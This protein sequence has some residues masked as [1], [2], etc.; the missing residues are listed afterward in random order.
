MG[1]W[2][3]ISFFSVHFAFLPLKIDPPN[4]EIFVLCWENSCLINMYK[5][6]IHYTEYFAFSHMHLAQV[7]PLYPS[8]VG[9]I[10]L[11]KQIYYV[12]STNLGFRLEIQSD[13]YLAAYCSVG[14]RLYLAAPLFN[15]RIFFP[16]KIRMRDRLGVT[17]SF[18]KNFRKISKS[19]FSLTGVWKC[20]L[21]SFLSFPL[22]HS[23]YLSYLRGHVTI[24]HCP[25]YLV[26]QTVTLLK[27]RDS[28]QPTVAKFRRSPPDPLVIRYTRSGWR[29]TSDE[30]AVY[31][32][33]K[34][35]FKSV[36]HDFRFHIC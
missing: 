2:V 36:Y 33:V 15:G 11:P 35:Q 3:E 19:L 32:Q 28:Y 17:T 25:E 18:D 4:S 20:D 29:T 34:F 14:I 27:S 1:E 22:S 24:M 31:K 23:P 9:V 12:F 13:L 6:V 8:V 16:Q 26:R 30:H 10:V 5:T 7:V 21:M